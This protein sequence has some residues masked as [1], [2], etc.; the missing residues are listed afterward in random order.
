MSAW[1]LV[2]E[3]RLNLVLL[4]WRILWAPN[5]ASRWQMRFNS[6]FKGLIS[7]FT[8]LWLTKSGWNRVSH[9]RNRTG[10]SRDRNEKQFS[11]IH[12]KRCISCIPPPHCLH[13]NTILLTYEHHTAY[14]RTPYCLHMN[15]TLL[16]YEHHTAYIRTPHCLHTNTILLTYEHHTAYIRTP[17]CLHS[18]TTRL[19][20]EHHTA[21]I[22]TRHCLHTNTILLT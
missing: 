11:S 8:S 4:T 7:Y 19:T 17:Y 9:G 14:I 22:R 16:T 5:N 1:S 12:G 18:K 21:Y 20:Y 6:A 15:T 10:N 3:G 2:P 13:T